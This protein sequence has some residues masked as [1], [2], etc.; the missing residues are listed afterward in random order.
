MIASFEGFG[1]R[2]IKL[3]T[4]LLNAYC[5]NPE[6]IDTDYIQIVFDESLGD[7]FIAD[8]QGNLY[9]CEY[10][11]AIGEFKLIKDSDDQ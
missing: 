9:S 3:A 11:K 6:I 5:A 4:N 8:D 1:Y 2:E 10:D 7:V